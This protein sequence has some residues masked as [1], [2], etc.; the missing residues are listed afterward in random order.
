VDTPECFLGVAVVQA[1]Y[2]GNAFAYV[3]DKATLALE[4]H[5][6]IFP[7]GQGVLVAASTLEGVSWAHR[8]GVE[9]NVHHRG[10]AGHRRVMGRFS[11]SRGAAPLDFDLRLADTPAQRVPAVVAWPVPGGRTAYTHK[12][13][14]LPAEGTIRVGQRVFRV[15]PQRCRGSMDH[16]RALMDYRTYWNWAAFSAVSDRGLP[17]AVNLDLV[18]NGGSINRNCFVWFG[19]RLLR[20]PLVHFE[21]G[22]PMSEWTLRTPDGRLNLRFHPQAVRRGSIQAGVIASRFVQPIGTFNGT[23]TTPEGDTHLVDQAWGVTEEHHAR[24]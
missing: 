20:A 23:L 15:E 4:E 10:A 1:G 13:D 9:V 21:Y 2:V 24:W 8:A 12:V 11:C 3:L 7:L 6:A 22:E 5:E 17:V 16:T 14:G 19:R 18:Q